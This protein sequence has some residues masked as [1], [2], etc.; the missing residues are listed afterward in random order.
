MQKVA[1]CLEVEFQQ[2]LLG[3]FFPPEIF[4]ILL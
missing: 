2:I 3:H 4:S 1:E